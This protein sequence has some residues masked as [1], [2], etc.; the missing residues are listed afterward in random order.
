MQAMIGSGAK[1]GKPG[2]L[3]ADAS[4]RKFLITFQVISFCRET[5]KKPQF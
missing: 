1:Q 2:V 4:R 3:I 5:R